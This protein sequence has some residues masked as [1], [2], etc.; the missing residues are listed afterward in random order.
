MMP[1]FIRIEITVLGFLLGSSL[2]A[3]S[4]PLGTQQPSTTA[5]AVHPVQFIEDVKMSS[6]EL[7]PHAPVFDSLGAPVKVAKANAFPMT[8]TAEELANRLP[9]PGSESIDEASDGD[10]LGDSS[11]DFEAELGQDFLSGNSNSAIEDSE[12]DTSELFSDPIEPLQPVEQ[13]PDCQ[14]DIC[15]LKRAG[16][17]VIDCKTAKEEPYARYHNA[18]C[19]SPGSCAVCAAQYAPAIP[20]CDRP[21]GCELGGWLSW[22]WY[23]NSHGQDGSIGNKPLGFNNLANELQMHQAWL[24][25]ERR[26]NRQSNQFDWG[27][28]ADLVF[29]T[30]A[31]DTQARNDE[32]WDGTWDTSREYGFALPQ[33]YVQSTWNRWSIKAGRF[34]TIIGYETV[35]A[36]DNFFYSHTYSMYYAQ[37][38]TH[39]GFLVDRPLG[40]NWRIYAG[41]SNGWDNGFANKFGGSAFVGGVS[42]SSSDRFAFTYTTSIGDPGAD[43]P[44]KNDVNMHSLIF[45]WA[46]GAGWNYVIHAS[47]E[48]RETDVA[49]A[50]GVFNSKQYGLTQY[51]IRRWNCRWSCGMRFENFYAGEGNG[52]PLNRQIATPGTHYHALTFG[53]NYR[54][55]ASLTMKPEMRYDWVD[56]DGPAGGPFDSGTRRSQFTVG[57]QSVWTF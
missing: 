47:G 57:M 24:Y 35:Q 29:G 51:L 37:P 31:P 43:V 15:R 5:P 18:R 53:L 28:R 26:I 30:D 36:P 14:C 20:A 4:L 46:L 56:F 50:P 25:A 27:Y 16:Y 49:L 41:W 10:V 38:F 11:G 54:P 40:E 48:F 2:F 3:Q 17:K 55:S 34:Y 44:G 1:R 33:L 21:G 8:P 12:F 13:D 7:V 22:G 6:D 52:V 19:V 9:P 32:S 42:Y 23:T 45:D 39:T